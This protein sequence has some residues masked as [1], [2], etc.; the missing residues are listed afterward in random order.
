MLIG[1]NFRTPRRGRPFDHEEVLDAIR[2]PMERTEPIPLPELG[3]SLLS[4]LS[5]PV[6]QDRDRTEEHRVIPLQTVQIQLCEVNGGDVPV[7]H[8]RRQAMHGQKRDVLFV[9]GH[10]AW[11]RRDLDGVAFER[12]HALGVPLLVQRSRTA[13]VGLVDQRG[14]L[15]VTE[16]YGGRALLLRGNVAARG[17]RNRPVSGKKRGWRDSAGGRSCCGRLEE[18]TAF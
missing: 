6:F 11:P 17:I 7:S 12:I 8:E 15:A 9:G 13:R 1:E 4:F 10:R 14:V 18:V 2:D 5:C 16:G 3:V